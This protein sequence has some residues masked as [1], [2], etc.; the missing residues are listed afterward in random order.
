MPLNLSTSC[1]ESHFTVQTPSSG[2]LSPL[3][4]SLPPFDNGALIDPTYISS[5]PASQLQTLPGSPPELPQSL[6]ITSLGR[7]QLRNWKTA[8]IL[9]ALWRYKNGCQILPTHR[10]QETLSLCFP[11]SPL[12]IHSSNFNIKINFRA[13]CV[14]LC[15]FS[16]SISECYSFAS[17]SRKNES[18][19]GTQH[20]DHSL[21]LEY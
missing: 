14:N 10:I 9:R 19:P 6:Q 4:T 18:W 17:I 20:T 15:E 1:P 2:S 16:Q 12:S 13:K 3:Q 5:P 21:N 8:S 7:R 11:I